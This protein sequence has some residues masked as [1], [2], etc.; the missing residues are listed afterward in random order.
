MFPKLCTVIEDVETIKIGANHLSTQR[1]VFPT[2]CT[3]K[4]GVNDVR[5]LSNNSVA[6]EAIHLKCKTL[7]RDRSAYKSLQQL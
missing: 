5:F 7:M 3:E 6:S 4:F 1:I 2:G